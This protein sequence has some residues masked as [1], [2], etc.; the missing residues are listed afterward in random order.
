MNTMYKY[1]CTNEDIKR[2][3]WYLATDILIQNSI[4]YTNVILP[5]VYKLQEALI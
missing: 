1:V 2:D 3:S 5:C 4:P